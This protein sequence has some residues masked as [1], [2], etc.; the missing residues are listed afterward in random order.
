V[1]DI[2]APKFEQMAKAHLH[3]PWAARDDYI[4]VILD[5]SSESFGAFLSRHA[6]GGLNKA[7]RTELLKLL[8]LHRHALLM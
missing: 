7:E 4:D 5:R 2:L 6:R 3:D 8:E 1:R